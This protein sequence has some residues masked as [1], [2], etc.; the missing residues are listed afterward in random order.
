MMK[1]RGTIL[2]GLTAMISIGI[3]ANAHARIKCNGAYQIVRGQSEIA[4]PYCEDEYL[5]RVARGYGMRV[6]G[7][8]IRHSPA[9]KQEVCRFM[10]HD[11]RISEI[12]QPY[13]RDGCTPFC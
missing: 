12:C 1:L 3:T 2:A 6:S 9:R 4:T 8:A 7:S 5:A 11:S 10:G 13:R